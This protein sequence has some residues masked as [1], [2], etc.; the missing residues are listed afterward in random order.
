MKSYGSTQSQLLRSLWLYKS[1]SQKNERKGLQKCDG[2]KIENNGN[3]PPTMLLLSRDVT[4]P[5]Q[6][7]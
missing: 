6:F 5:K 4:T 3:G 7:A 2:Q 1:L